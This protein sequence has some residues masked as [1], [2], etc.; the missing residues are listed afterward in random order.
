MSHITGAVVLAVALA[1]VVA[2]AGRGAGCS[3]SYG[4]GIY[5]N[6]SSTSQ[7][8][9]STAFQVNSTLYATGDVIAYYSDSRLKE[10]IKTIENALAKVMQIRGVTY[11]NNAL[12]ETFGYSDKSKQ[13]GVIAQELQVVLPEVVAPAPF[14]RMEDVNGKTIGSKSGEFYT[15]VKYER[16][17]PLLIEAIKEL[18]IQ[19]ENLSAQLKEN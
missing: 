6:G 15:T 4:G 14:D 18:N 8:Y 16:I 9:N 7:T 2:V 13:V 19:V 11:N 10:N 17:V 5:F 1:V 3:T 12:A